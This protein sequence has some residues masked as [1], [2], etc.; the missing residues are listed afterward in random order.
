[1]DDLDRLHDRLVTNIHEGFPHLLERNFRLGD[2]TEHLVPYRTNRPALRFDSARQ[3]EL[4]LMRLAAGERGYLR[5]EPTVAD[6]FRRALAAPDP[7]AAVLRD[8]ALAS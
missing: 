7:D 3:Y 5:V 2:I 1:M 8:H 6:A 4:A